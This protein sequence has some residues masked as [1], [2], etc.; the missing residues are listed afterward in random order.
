MDSSFYLRNKSLR[1]KT[2]LRKHPRNIYTLYNEIN[3]TE[4]NNMKKHITL[5]ENPLYD[6]IRRTMDY[7]FSNGMV[8]GM[9]DLNKL[10]DRWSEVAQDH[11]NDEILYWGEL[12]KNR[13]AIIKAAI[14]DAFNDYL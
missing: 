13:I 8:L 7:A 1:R 5:N 14:K 4:V 10:C 2:S 11:I 3:F 12:K 9:N 6:E